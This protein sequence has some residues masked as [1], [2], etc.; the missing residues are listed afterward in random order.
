MRLYL[1]QAEM[2]GKGPTLFHRPRI[3][4]HLPLY[5]DT[6]S[7]LSVMLQ[8][9]C[10]ACP[11]GNEFPTRTFPI[12][13]PPWSHQ[14]AKKVGQALR[15]AIDS[16]RY[17]ETSLRVPLKVPSACASSPTAPD[18]LGLVLG[19][20]LVTNLAA[21]RVV[22]GAVAS[23]TTQG[24]HMRKVAALVLALTA[25][26]LTLSATPASAN[27]I[28]MGPPGSTIL[29]IGWPVTVQVWDPGPVTVNPTDCV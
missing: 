5:A 4:R 1:V 14:C 21:G 16:P 12:G 17:T 9:G 11:D 10:D 13:V 19:P 7:K 18:Y 2:S 3:V 29:Y 22:R 23:Q 20:S 15:R 24:G 26:A 25:G 27:C 28:E 8:R 6:A